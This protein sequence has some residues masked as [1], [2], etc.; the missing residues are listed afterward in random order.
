MEDLLM[1][2]LSRKVGD[3]IVI[4]DNII[5]VINRIMGNRV[6]IG[7]DAPSDVHILRGELDTVRRQLTPEVS[8]DTLIV[9]TD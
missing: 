7:L 4:N 8:P 3:R 2:V 6:Q 5:I 9:P 1:L